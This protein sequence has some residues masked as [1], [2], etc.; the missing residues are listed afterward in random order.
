MIVD[1]AMVYTDKDG[2]KWKPS[3]FEEKFYGD[4][5]FRQALIHSR[6]IPTI[7]IVRES[8]SPERHSVRQANWNAGRS[9]TPDLS[10]SLGSGATSPME[11]ARTYALFP[12]LGRKVG[13]DLRDQGDRSR[14]KVLEEDEARAASGR[15]QDSAAWSG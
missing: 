13:S 9:S 15:S 3:N 2:V 4:T 5:T 14:G 10:I 6:N 12:R 11:M 8:S 1:N 7:K